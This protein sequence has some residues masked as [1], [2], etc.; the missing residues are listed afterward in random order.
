[1]A[2][3]AAAQPDER[4]RQALCRAQAAGRCIVQELKVLHAAVAQLELASAADRDAALEKVKAKGLPVAVYCDGAV[5]RDVQR[6]LAT[7]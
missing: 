7:L 3:R 5:L 6:H 2:H 4:A 1:M